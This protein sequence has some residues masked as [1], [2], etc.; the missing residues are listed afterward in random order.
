L[1]LLITATLGGCANFQKMQDAQQYE[2]AS[3]TCRG[4]VQK[5]NLAGIMREA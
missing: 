4:E 2:I 3:T 5:A 1:L